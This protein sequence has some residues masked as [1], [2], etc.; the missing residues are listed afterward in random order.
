M[1]V[2]AINKVSKFTR[3]IHTITRDYESN[4]AVPSAATMFFVNELGIAITCKH[5]AERLNKADSVNN[6]YSQFKNVNY[7]RLHHWMFFPWYW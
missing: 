2:K 1:F 7:I 4:F 6:K 5:V 3:P